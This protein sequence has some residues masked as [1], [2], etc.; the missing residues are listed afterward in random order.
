MDKSALL[1]R[2]MH[3]DKYELCCNRAT[4][5]GKFLIKRI[6]PKKYDIQRLKSFACFTISVMDGVNQFPSRPKNRAS[7]ARSKANFQVTPNFLKIYRGMCAIQNSEIV[8]NEDLLAIAAA[9]QSVL[10]GENPYKAFSVPG[11]ETRGLKPIGSIRSAQLPELDVARMVIN[12]L[13]RSPNL[14]NPKTFSYQATANELFIS[15]RRVRSQFSLALSRTSHGD[16]KKGHEEILSL[17]FI[18]S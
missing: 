10:L 15:E 12:N 17:F 14:K 18:N 7:R 3:W 1:P 9:S 11:V 4:T 6:K 16:C 2:T 5:I 13:S 8:D